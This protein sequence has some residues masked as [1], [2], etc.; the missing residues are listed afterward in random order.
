MLR[1]AQGREL[2]I[3]HNCC[4]KVGMHKFCCCCGGKCSCSEDDAGSGGGEIPSEFGGYGSGVV[5]WFRYLSCMFFLFFGLS[6]LSVPSA[7]IYS[8]S[9]DWDDVEAE[10]AVDGLW[11]FTPANL[12]EAASACSLS[13][14][15]DAT[16]EASCPAGTRV[17][18]VEAY[19]AN[20]QGSCE[21]PASQVPQGFECPD[22]IPR[23][24][25]T[26]TS[27]RP[28]TRIVTS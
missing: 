9:T 8:A 13:E 25:S 14:S 10:S 20:L 26:C 21:C 6:V 17:S 16:L 22:I 4:A 1:D 11:R 28:F 5:L 12:G 19:Y 18:R 3:H 15:S 2:L 24:S 7:L 23:G 27:G